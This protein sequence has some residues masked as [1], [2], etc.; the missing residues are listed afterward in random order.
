MIARAAALCLLVLLA[1]L[2]SGHAQEEILDFASRIDVQPNGDLIVEETIR[3]R[4][5]GDK[6][7]RGIYRDFPTLYRGWMGLRV[8][9]PF[10]VQSVTRDGTK[11]NWRTTLRSNGVRLYI[12]SADIPLRPGIV[13]YQIRYRTARQLGF[14][15]DHD[16]L[17][18]NVTG[19]GWD[20]P[21]L[22]ASACV[23]L[24][25]GTPV[26][27]V[28]AFTGASGSKDGNFQTPARAGCDAFFLT[29]TPLS[30][31]EGL[32]IVVNWPKGYVSPPTLQNEVTA[33]ILANRGLVFG[34]VGLL[35]VAV[36]FS[37]MWFV[38][39]RDP[40]SGPIIAQFAPPDGLNPQDVRYLN[41]LGTCDDRSF[42][43]AVLH[44][45]V[46]RALTIQD[47]AK[48][49]FSLI[50]NP[51]AQLD[52]DEDALWRA[53]FS[54]GS[55]LEL[56]QR[57]HQTVQAAKKQL[58]QS[59]SAKSS[60]LFTTNTT[61]W[62]VGLV[63]TLAPLGVS[64]LDASEPTGAIFMLVWMTIWSVGCA[65][66][67]NGVVTALRGS[68]KWSAIPLALFSI[69]FF[70]GW[71]FGFWMLVQAASIWVSVI[72]LCGITM[73]GLF[74]YLLKRPSVEGQ[75]ARD[76]IRGF[77]HYLAVAEADRLNLE[78]PPDR[79]PELFEKFLP[80]A[81]ALGVEQEWAENF[82]GIL[83]AA[84]ECPD[85]YEGSVRG[86]TAAGIATVLGSSFAGA[87][88]SAS[89][90]PGSSSGGGGGGG[91]SSGGGG[92]GGGGGGW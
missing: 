29:T 41:G 56:V 86:F 60:G 15:A 38:F 65:A 23:N 31:G 4:A 72:Y 9:V 33:V 21:I 6:I 85:W 47:S 42:A 17:Y 69:P 13:T 36:Y 44:L 10:D 58:R 32:T 84:G 49:K 45:A 63:L 90:A 35:L 3:V 27:S 37:A 19:N 80:Y 79:T 51:S 57:N 78:N 76:H 75:R 8:E 50:K 14:F 20:F 53:I 77:R 39:G 22:K 87:I 5:A 89:T 30:S 74:H 28:N 55:P 64:L 12:G 34:G 73:C 40:E 7:K 11:E 25:P 62:V 48:A 70:I 82:S 71:L 52:P 92:G 83:E 18:W 91:G 16:E 2:R 1:S 46:Q 88:S 26:Q 67:S 43:S 81:L 54:D 68:Q 24:P 59:V 66:L 61:F